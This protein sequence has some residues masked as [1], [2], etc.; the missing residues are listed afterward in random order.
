M[1]Q[2][3]AFVSLVNDRAQFAACQQ[4]LWAQAEPLPPW[5]MVEPNARGWNAAEG[6]N[7][8]IGQADADWILCVHQDLLFPA[9]W[10]G[11]LRA[12][13]AALPAD[14]AVAGLVGTRRSGRF[15]G[16]ILDPNGHCFWPPLPAEVLTVD[17]HVIAIRRASGLRFDPA[18][19]GFHCYG[20]DLC[21]QAR[22]QGRRVMVID[23]PVVHLST[24][25]LDPSY[26]RASQWLLAKW[27][28]EVG[29]ILPTPTIIVQDARRAGW[30]RRTLFR[31]RRRRDRLQRNASCGDPR[32]GQGVAA[33]KVGA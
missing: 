11:R 30:L 25:R 8:G 7:W 28:A 21:L 5:L 10:W 22:R 27:G 17:E 32:C 19:P 26:D 31:W 24:G 20:A 16:H 33:A 3:I 2:S 13:L 12:Q 14:V 1:S 18:T 6:L 9:G 15:R 4:S 29:W 23:A